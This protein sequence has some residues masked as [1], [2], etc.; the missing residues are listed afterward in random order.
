MSQA[1]PR[2]ATPQRAAQVRSG[3]RVV[4]QSNGIRIVYGN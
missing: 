1:S 2:A 3:P 4:R